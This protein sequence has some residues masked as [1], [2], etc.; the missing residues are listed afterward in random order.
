MFVKYIFRW[1]IGTVVVVVISALTIEVVSISLVGFQINQ[2]S[3]IAFKQ[4]CRYFSQETYKR[5]DASL[6]NMSDIV[7]SQGL[8]IVSGKFYD[9]NDEQEVYDNLYRRNSAF[10]NWASEHRGIWKNFD[11]LLLG[12]GL[13]TQAGTSEEELYISKFYYESRMTPMNFGIS[14]LDRDVVERIAKWNLAELFSAGNE[15][16]VVD[17]G[18]NEP[19][20]RYKGFRI[21]PQRAAIKDIK[22]DVF[23]VVTQKEEFQAITNI[24]S[25][26]LGFDGPNDDRAKVCVATISYTVPVAYEGVTPLKRIMMFVWNR[27]ANMANNEDDVLGESEIMSDGPRALP[28]PGN[29]VFTVLE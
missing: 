5:E 12:M 15:S 14:Y 6:G 9:G 29:I 7:N 13:P 17:D 10:R 26:K 18:K 25:S 11:L 1:L 21:Y 8:P 27:E 19:F 24:D 28:V 4:A 3:R 16:V 20:V 23:N 22:Y 2:L